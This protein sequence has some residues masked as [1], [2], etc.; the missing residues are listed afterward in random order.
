MPFINIVIYSLLALTAIVIIQ[1]FRVVPSKTILVVERLGK[2][3]RTL[4]AGFHILMPV[5][6]KVAYKHNMKEIALDVPAQPAFT[7]DNVR[8]KIDGVLY[9]RV[10]DARKAS[11]AVDSYRVAAIQL[12]QTTMRSVIGLLELDKTFEERENINARILK[13]I[14]E[15]CD[16][17]GVEITRYEIQN[18][19]V[20]K[21]ILQVMEFQMKA[22]RDKRA[23]IAKSMGEMESRI[24][25]S[26]GMM[27][28]SI[29]KSEGEK[30]RLI[31]EAEGRASEVLALSRAAAVSIEKIAEAISVPGGDDAVM[32]QNAERLITSLGGAA[33]PGKKILLPMDLSKPDT[34]LKIIR[35]ATNAF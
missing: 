8:V 21:N 13:N 14:N 22:E 9:L 34:I 23:S 12:A 7:T 18:I 15:A 28:E 24:N 11:Y 26:S 17:W 3:S 6:D 16:E 5:F 33:A 27:E 31:N 32:Y 2:F 19:Q 29:N 30:Q 4:E 1:N 10:K 35:E 20:P 25:Y